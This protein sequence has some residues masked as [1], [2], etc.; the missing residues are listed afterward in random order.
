[1][2]LLATLLVAIVALTGLLIWQVKERAGVYFDNRCFA[3][4]NYGD[5]SDNDLLFKGNVTFEFNENK[6]GMFNISGN[7]E[8]QGNYYRLSRY[9]TFTYDNVSGNQYRMISATKDIM[10]HDNVPA[11]I[12]PLASKVF[13]LNGEYTVYLYKKDNNFI[14]FAN[15]LLPLMNCVIQ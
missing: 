7:I 14:T 11:D 2:K 5:S 13:G 1:M 4:V 15:A 3:N 10:A 12:E 6:T 9:V 8:Y